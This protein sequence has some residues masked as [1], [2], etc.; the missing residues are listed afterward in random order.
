MAFDDGGG[1][2]KCRMASATAPGG[3]GGAIEIAT[4]TTPSASFAEHGCRDAYIAVVAAEVALATRMQRVSFA[5]YI[6]FSFAAVI[7]GTVTSP[8]RSGERIQ[9]ANMPCWRA[10]ATMLMA[11]NTVRGSGSF[12]ADSGAFLCVAAAMF[13]AS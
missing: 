8:S 3:G 6:R 2:G 11:S 4:E 5:R 12:P 1:G 7:I 9:K 10:N 13:V